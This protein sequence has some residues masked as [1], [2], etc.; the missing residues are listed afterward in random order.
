MTMGGKR[1]KM[2]QNRK[3]RTKRLWRHIW[4]NSIDRGRIV[5]ASASFKMWD[6]GKKWVVRDWVWIN[7]ASNQIINVI[8]SAWNN[9]IDAGVN[10]RLVI[11]D[12]A[13]QRNLFTY[14]TCTLFFDHAFYGGVCVCVCVEVFF[15]NHSFVLF[16][17]GWLTYNKIC[18]INVKCFLVWFL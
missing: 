17:Y 12:L 14:F 18:K 10:Y 8:Y 6:Y 3:T 9:T 4:W 2:K 15:S 13:A 1:M 11:K 7:D 5:L 16:Y